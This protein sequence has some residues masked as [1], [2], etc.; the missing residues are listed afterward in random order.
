MG[1]AHRA[2]LDDKAFKAKEA[3]G[4]RGLKLTG[5]K[6]KQA[7][8]ALDDVRACDDTLD[9]LSPTD[10]AHV[11]AAGNALRRIQDKLPGPSKI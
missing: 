8:R 10:L 9:H 3:K 6:A 4:R 1:I 2:W 11:V 7:V 5:R